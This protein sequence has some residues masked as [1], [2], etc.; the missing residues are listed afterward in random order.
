MYWIDG[1]QIFCIGLNT[2]VGQRNIETI[3][4]F[5]LTRNKD[6]LCQPK[7]SQ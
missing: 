5:E 3:S 6:V 7:C 1:K 4:V 2:C